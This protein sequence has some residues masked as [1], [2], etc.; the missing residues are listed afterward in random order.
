MNKPME[1]IDVGFS[2]FFAHLVAHK[3]GQCLWMQEIAF[4]LVS[5]PTETLKALAGHLSRAYIRMR[6]AIDKCDTGEVILY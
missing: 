4:N 3:G 5:P 6:I 1:I 2:A